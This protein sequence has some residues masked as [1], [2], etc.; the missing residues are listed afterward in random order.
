MRVGVRR[1]GWGAAAFVCVVVTGSAG[2]AI[3]TAAAEPVPLQ[4]PTAV[5]LGDVPA[6]PAPV[7][8]ALPPSPGS[9]GRGQA[10]I[11]NDAAFA[12]Q[13]VTRAFG[14]EPYQG[15]TAAAAA[16]APARSAQ[17]TPLPASE[18]S[19]PAVTSL[20]AGRLDLFTRSSDGDLL[21]QY[22]PAR[23]SWTR[24]LG[25]GGDIRSQPA[26]VSWATGRLDVFVRGTDDALW[27]RWYSA[28]HWSG[29]ES[30]GGRLTS[31][32]AIVSWAPGRLDVFV[33]GA[34]SALWRKSY[35]SGQGWSGWQGLGGVLT[36]SPAAASWAP[37]RLDVF[38][39]GG[40]DAAYHRSF[41]TS[42]GWSGWVRLGGIVT[43]QPAA[44]S[45]GDGRLDLAFRGADGVLWLK[46]YVSGSGWTGWMSLGG[47]FNS[48]P[49]ATE[50]GDDVWIVGRSPNGLLYESVRVSPAAAWSRWTRVDEYL[51]FRRLGTWVDAFDYAT[52]DPAIEVP[53][54]KSRGVRV[55]YLATARFNG[56]SDFLDAAEAGQW[57]DLAHQNGIKVVGWYLPAY[58]DMTR[59][60]RRTV[61][62]AQFVSPNGER[63]DAVGVDIERLD[64]VS[65]AQF[66]LLLVTHLSQV[67]AQIAT[68]IGAIVPSPFA[69]DPGNRWAGF[70]WGAVGTNSDVVL[71]M[72]LW[73]FRSNTDGS[74]YTANQVYSW[75][76][77]QTQ[78]A[79]LLTGR[80]VSVEGGVNDPG[81][82]RTPVTAERVS[83]FVD[84][85][86]DG[87]AIGGSHYDY[88]TTEISFWTILTGL[89]AL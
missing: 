87:D 55:L 66:N 68:M 75:V 2:G 33:R 82:E 13:P 40:S 35:M 47:Q 74:A 31:A 37:G 11:T 62:I 20:E 81:T 89:N 86:I 19:S 65:L 69:T 67:R 72:A 76:L 34:D 9:Q 70:P 4:S 23:G 60:V 50:T 18:L 5:D 14:V 3:T 58:G 78:R 53:A 73:S 49:G 41:S 38:V 29:W 24:V 30:L 54:M 84:A 8:A 28:G 83:R 36:S 46:R 63:F 59:D 71:P 12:A 27:H 56:T 44:A 39:R 61:A 26:A 77:D 7:P 88:A 51:P 21:H 48:G 52:L 64:E 85:V 79:R 1:L 42:A 80:P 17:V 16:E 32:P 25:L 43:S 10:D 45:P 6:E 57:L 15:T 22:R